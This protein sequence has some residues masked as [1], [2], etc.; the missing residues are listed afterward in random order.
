MKNVLRNGGALE[1]V[2]MTEK[3]MIRGLV[4][5]H[6]NDIGAVLHWRESNEMERALDERD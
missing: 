4:F 1:N 2:S 5:G 6:S 3:M